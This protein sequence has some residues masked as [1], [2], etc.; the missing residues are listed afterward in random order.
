[1][2]IFKSTILSLVFV[3]ISAETF[4]QN[5]KVT[6]TVS[7]D[8]DGWQNITRK[9]PFAKIDI[10]DW[11]DKEFIYIHDSQSIDALG[12]VSFKDRS[13]FLDKKICRVLEVKRK[14]SF[15]Q[16]LFV[17]FPETQ[18]TGTI[19]SVYDRVFSLQYF[20]DIDSLKMQL[21]GKTIYAI[22]VKR[23]FGLIDKG[24]KFRT[25][26]D[27]IK[28]IS[29]LVKAVNNDSSKQS[30]AQLLLLASDGRE[31][32]TEVEPSATNR[33]VKYTRGFY[34]SFLDKKPVIRSKWIQS[35]I[36]GDISAGMNFDEVLISWGYPNARW[37]KK[38]SSGISERWEYKKNILLFT[39][40]VL[41]DI[42][43]G[44]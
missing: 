43:D 15:S 33:N 24:K 27:F 10:N 34:E 1:M 29:F 12:I 39:N 35:I 5:N 22:N 23:W 20:K 38:N 25:A 13:E 16:S 44:L 40:G 21:E 42:I 37:L 8:N 36:K 31:T 28:K 32:K 3:L 30:S 4:A 14:Y 41:V 26:E 19:L 7:S 11:K 6:D 2:N 17:F 9:H 18:D